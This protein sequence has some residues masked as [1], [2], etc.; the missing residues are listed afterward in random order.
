M[1]TKTKAEAMRLA[2][3][4]AVE[5]ADLFPAPLEFRGADK[6]VANPEMPGAE[7]GD[8]YNA[9]SIYVCAVGADNVDRTLRNLHSNWRSRGW[10]SRLRPLDEG[11]DIKAHNPVD[12]FRY[13]VMTRKD[14]A[15]LSLLVDSPFYRDPEPGTQT[16]PIEP[17]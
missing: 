9:M 1:E 4:K 16:D 7:N 3:D 12:D 6:A 14:K 2:I 15:S 17:V 8:V 5:I 13:V 10:E 11:G